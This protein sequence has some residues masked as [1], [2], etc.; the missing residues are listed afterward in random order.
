MVLHQLLRLRGSWSHSL[1]GP[2]F[3]RFTNS[4]LS[5]TPSVVG[6]QASLGPR[7]AKQCEL[8]H[9]LRVATVIAALLSS[10]SALDLF[11]P[12]CQGSICLCCCATV[13]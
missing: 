4:V 5:D 12:G 9:R 6:D 1:S 7:W 2:T 8:Y 13:D 3:A 10:I 11:Q